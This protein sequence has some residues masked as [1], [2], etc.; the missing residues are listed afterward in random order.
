[1]MIDS[2]A[3][4][5]NT[6]WH[7]PLGK[8]LLAI[9]HMAFAAAKQVCRLA[10]DILPQFPLMKHQGL[11][12]RRT[13]ARPTPT[14]PTPT[15]DPDHEAATAQFLTKLHRLDELA[16]DSEAQAHDQQAR[17]DDIAHQKDVDDMLKISGS[18]EPVATPATPRSR[19]AEGK[20]GRPPEGKR[21]RPP[22]GVSAVAR[23]IKAGRIALN[24]GSDQL[25]D[26]P[27]QL[28]DG[29][30]S[31]SVRDGAHLH[32]AADPVGSHQ[33]LLINRQSNEGAFSC[34]SVARDGTHLHLAA[35]PV[36][37]QQPL[38]INRQ[39]NDGAFGCHSVARNGAHLHLAAGPVGSQHLPA[40]NADRW[41]S[42]ADTADRQSPPPPPDGISS[43]GITSTAVDE[44]GSMQ[45]LLSNRN[46]GE[47]SVQHPVKADEGGEI[48]QVMVVSRFAHEWRPTGIAT[49]RCIQC[50]AVASACPTQPVGG[51]CTGLPRAIASRSGRGHV[52]W[53]FDPTEGSPFA[54]Y[55]CCQFCGASGSQMT[56][57]NLSGPCYGKWTSATTKLAWHR[58]NDGRH[59]HQRHKGRNLF[60]PGVPLL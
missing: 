28:E 57:Q 5:A 11:F 32:L 15:T 54:A 48:H 39:G 26:M 2:E 25:D 30:P 51:A 40:S 53:R 46:S 43:T 18:R 29:L 34:H 49:W 17:I 52:L 56:W 31:V 13:S 47:L 23:L 4:K 12:R 16:F 22:E 55:V 59:P 21:S 33:S 42:R 27:P 10:A 1:M 3:D 38:L 44:V 60:F 7:E 8:D 14:R 19:P 24:P 50:S 36:G 41:I 20:R 37:P 6:A 35:D 9:D 58:L 45:H